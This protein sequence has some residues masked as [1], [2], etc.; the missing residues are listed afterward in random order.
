MLQ[1]DP[2]ALDAA[3]RSTL[4]EGAISPDLTKWRVPCLIYVGAEVPQELD[5]FEDAGEH[6]LKGVPD[7][8]NICR[9]VGLGRVQAVDRKNGEVITASASIRPRLQKLRVRWTRGNHTQKDRPRRAGPSVLRVTR[10][11]LTS[12]RTLQP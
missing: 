9:V 11:D 8:W 3:F 7:R 2:R 4:L 10:A 12:G 5:H 6:E 1:N